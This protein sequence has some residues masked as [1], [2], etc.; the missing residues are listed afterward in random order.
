MQDDLKIEQLQLV[1]EQL[2][3]ILMDGEQLQL[4]SKHIGHGTHNYNK[5]LLLFCID[6]E[7]F[8]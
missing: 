1:I 8:R 3:E 6:V 2:R 5:N 4:F 7:A